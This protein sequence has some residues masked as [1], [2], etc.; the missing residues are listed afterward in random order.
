MSNH[1]GERS[2]EGRRGGEEH[3]EDEVQEFMMSDR[4]KNECHGSYIYSFARAHTHTHTHT[5]IHARIC[6]LVHTHFRLHT[7]I[8]YDQFL[9]DEVSKVRIT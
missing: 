7:L 5:H 2:V 4:A 8:E 3:R 9:E 6:P 1:K